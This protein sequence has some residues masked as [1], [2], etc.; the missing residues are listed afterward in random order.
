FFQNTGAVA[1]IF[2]AV[3]LIILA[4]LVFLTTFIIRR[5][6]QAKFNRELD[7]AT[8]EAANTSVPSYLYDEHSYEGKGAALNNRAHTRQ[9]MNAG[10]YGIREIDHDMVGARTG[11][12][13][14]T[15]YEYDL[16]VQGYGHG[17]QAQGYISHAHEQYNPYAAPTSTSYNP[18]SNPYAHS[19]ADTSQDGQG[20]PYY[21]GLDQLLETAGFDL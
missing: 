19:Q 15:G 3:G 17:R 1:G 10:M 8:A 5:R 16:Y 2:T 4:L 11:V 12:G 20:Q 21:R 14:E 6:R 7:E 18:T 9:P 13:N